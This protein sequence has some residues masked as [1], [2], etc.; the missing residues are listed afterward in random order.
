MRVVRRCTAGQ[1]EAPRWDESGVR[2]VG[3]GKVVEW[4]EW[5][6]DGEDGIK[7]GV[8]YGMRMGKM[9][10]NGPGCGVKMGPVAMRWGR[11]GSGRGRDYEVRDRW[12]NEHGEG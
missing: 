4:G 2:T 8:R 3:I 9:V 5:G 1:G 6:D 12:G 7:C 11:S 10:G